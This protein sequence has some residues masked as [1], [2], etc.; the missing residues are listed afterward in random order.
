MSAREDR[1]SRAVVESLILPTEPWLSCDE[2]FELMDE[3]AD[4]VVGGT[5][6]PRRAA[7]E[8]HLGACPACSEEV[9]SLVELL[10]ED[11]GSS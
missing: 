8:V 1:L 11:A 9:G 10:R 4:A 6:P 7:M 3:F 5:E 2:C